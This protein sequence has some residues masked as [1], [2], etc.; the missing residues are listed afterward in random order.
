MRLDFSL[1]CSLL[2]KDLSLIFISITAA[3][4]VP[5]GGRKKSP[6]TSPIVHIIFCFRSF[7]I[8]DDILRTQKLIIGLDSFSNQ[9][10]IWIILVFVLTKPLK[11]TLFGSMLPNLMGH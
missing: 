8:S 1:I 5:C 4:V 10:I 9:W 11:V 2:L 6:R 7:E 3:G